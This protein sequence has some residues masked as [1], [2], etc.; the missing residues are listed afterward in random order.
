MPAP[1]Q[2]KCNPELLEF[3]AVEGRRLVASFDGGA[4]HTGRVVQSGSIDLLG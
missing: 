2:T 3:P 4:I 1:M